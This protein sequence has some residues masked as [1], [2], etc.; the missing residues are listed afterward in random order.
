MSACSRHQTQ[1]GG[2]IYDFIFFFFVTSLN[3]GGLRRLGT[4][5][6][7]EFVQLVGEMGAR[8]LS[9]KEDLHSLI[10]RDSATF[11]V[12]GQLRKTRFSLQPVVALK[13]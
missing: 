2:S 9:N 10:K 12:R 1:P 5:V 8:H 7:F 3:L 6:I 4:N 13:M 11:S